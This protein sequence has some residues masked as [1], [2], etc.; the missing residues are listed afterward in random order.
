MFSKIAKRKGEEIAEEVKVETA[1]AAQN[2]RAA[3]PAPCISCL[4]VQSENC[5]KL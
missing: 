4:V 2:M 5:T 1:Q 3:V